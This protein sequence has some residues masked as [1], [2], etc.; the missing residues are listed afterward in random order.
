M[1]KKSLID[2]YVKEYSGGQMGAGKLRGILE[3]FADDLA[4]ITKAREGRRRS[5]PKAR[6]VVPEPPERA[7]YRQGCRYMGLN[8]QCNLQSKFV[9]PD[10]ATVYC[11]GICMRMKQWDTKN[12]YKGIGFKLIND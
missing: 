1:T 8:S 10:Q 5:Y 2:S 6:K 9:G 12:G 3:S 11:N 4:D 7:E